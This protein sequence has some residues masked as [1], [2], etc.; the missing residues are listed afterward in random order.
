M[1]RFLVVVAAFVLIGNSFV[2]AAGPKEIRIGFTVNDFNDLWVTFMMD[3]VKKW[4]ERTPGVTVTL[5]NGQT[6]VSTQLGIVET[7]INQGYDA[8]IVKP[9]EIEATVA[10]AKAAKAANIPYVAVQQGIKEADARVLQNSVVTGEVQMQAVA[11]KLGGKGNV[12]I[13]MGEPGTL[14]AQERLQGNKNVLA[15]YPNMHLVAEE[16]GNWQRDQGMNIMENWLQA[17]IPIDAVVA[18]NDEMAIGAI[19]ALEA[20]K[21]R[22]KYIVAGIDATPNALQF[23]KE[24]RLD[25]TMFADA[26]TLAETSLDVAMQLI[27]KIKPKDVIISDRLVT[28]TNVDEYLALYKK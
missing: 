13:M 6:D 8:I 22:S 12:A 14:I 23:M 3:A 11:D 9:V 21:V 7:W 10:M 1:K 15:K 28:P 4:D 16:V 17:G 5:G 27:K 2:F 19:L 24:G 18:S 25:I 26:K 20:A